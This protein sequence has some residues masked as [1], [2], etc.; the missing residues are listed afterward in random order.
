MRKIFRGR[1]GG[2]RPPEIQSVAVVV[3]YDA[4][5]R[6]V[7]LSSTHAI[8]LSSVREILLAGVRAVGEEEAREISSHRDAAQSPSTA[9]P[10]A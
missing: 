1:N 6:S 8:A 2:G 4:R 5:T 9:S 7:A 3:L 10:P